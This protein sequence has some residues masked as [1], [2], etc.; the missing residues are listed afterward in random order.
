MFALTNGSVLTA[1]VAHTCAIV[2]QCCLVLPP[3]L[4][5]RL[6]SFCTWPESNGISPAFMP[7]RTEPPQ[8]FLC[9]R[10]H[11][12]ELSL[13]ELFWTLCAYLCLYV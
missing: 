7:A 8:T 11:C 6:P 1:C 2:C 4:A 9:W 13:C 3:L 12:V 5:V 10:A